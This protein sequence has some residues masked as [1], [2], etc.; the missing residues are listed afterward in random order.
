MKKLPNAF[1]KDLH[2]LRAK[3]GLQEYDRDVLLPATEEL[4]RK[5]EV[6]AASLLRDAANAQLDNAEKADDRAAEGLFPLDGQVA[7]GERRRINRGR[8][9]LGQLYRRKVVIDTNLSGQHHSWNN[10]T[11]WINM[12]IA[13]LADKALD[14]V[15]EDVAPEEKKAA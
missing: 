13:A 4:L 8:M 2:D 5:Y 15:V 6:N 7:L 11:R 3:H 10:E 1:Y 12:M 14:V 9:G